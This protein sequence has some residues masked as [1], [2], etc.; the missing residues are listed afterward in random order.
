M[1]P[2]AFAEELERAWEER[3]PIEPLSD[4]GLKGIEA[5]YRVQEAWNA[6]RLGKGDRVVG[7][8]IGL[9]SKAVQEQLGVDQ[10]DFGHLWESRFFGVGERVEVEASLFLQ[11][12]VEGELAFLIGRRLEGP[13]VTPQ[14]VLAATEAVAFALEIVDSRV[15]DWRIRLEDTVAD[16]ASFGGFLV[17]PWERALLEEDLSA[18]GLVLY[19]NGEAVAQGTGAACLGHP[20]RAV[21]WL[22]NTLAAFGVALEPGD[23]VMS[24][25]WAPVQPAGPGDLFTLVGTGGRALA[26]R[27]V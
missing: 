5:A 25:A 20:A 3:R 22:A 15:R 13:G 19:K 8:K 21:A 9:T 23:I 17:A 11:P 10:P 4:R 18:L 24:G 16:N 14:E 7:R 12:R 1:N 2:E 6:L 26:L 27:F